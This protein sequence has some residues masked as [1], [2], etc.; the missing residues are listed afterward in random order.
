MPSAVRLFF[1]TNAPFGAFVIL[2]AVHDLA[3]LLWSCIT[4]ILPLLLIC[5]N[6]GLAMG[7]HN[8]QEVEST[9]L[10][11]ALIG[12]DAIDRGDAFK[13]G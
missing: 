10:I 12:C 13:Q 1:S 11:T 4:F 6:V 2:A 8:P 9:S 3:Y 7:D 5:R